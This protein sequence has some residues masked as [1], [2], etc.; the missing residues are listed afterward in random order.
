MRVRVRLGVLGVCVGLGVLGVGGGLGLVEVVEALVLRLVV[1]VQR[2]RLA[3][4]IAERIGA[5]CGQTEVRGELLPLLLLLLLMRVLLLLLLLVG[6]MRGDIKNVVRGVMGVLVCG[7]A[8]RR[9][10]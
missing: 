10:R 3:A 6:G 5:V 7:R 1:G 8:L 4:Q 2:A 9:A